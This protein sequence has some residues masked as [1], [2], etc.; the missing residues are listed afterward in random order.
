MP[1]EY[2][3]PKNIPF[4]NRKIL[5]VCSDAEENF[6]H[7]FC[8][9]NQPGSKIYRFYSTQINALLNM[10]AIQKVYGEPSYLITSGDYAMGIAA[11]TESDDFRTDLESAWRLKLPKSLSYNG[12]LLRPIDP[13]QKFEVSARQMKAHKLKRYSPQKID[14]KAVE[15]LCDTT[16]DLVV[17]ILYDLMILR[18]FI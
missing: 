16:E 8:Y 1:I 6:I 18:G 17:K 11:S 14:R 7:A 15:Y 13:E 9:S 12:V 5:P 10:S 4:S 3:Y 2:P